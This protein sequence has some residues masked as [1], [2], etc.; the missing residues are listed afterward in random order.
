MQAKEFFDLV[1]SYYASK[2]NA[3]VEYQQCKDDLSR[4]K[5]H[6]KWKTVIDAKW[7]L[8]ACEVKRVHHAQASVALS[9]QQQ[10][11]ENLQKNVS[12][13]VER[14]RINGCELEWLKKEKDRLMVIIK[15]K[16]NSINH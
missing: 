10:T 7:S 2:E 4:K 13:I 11:L 14:I 12:H 3:M 6:N 9:E 15:M 16:D 5:C 8:I 1:S